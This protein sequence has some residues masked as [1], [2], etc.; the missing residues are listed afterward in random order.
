MAYC[1][2]ASTCA[3]TL[4]V[5][6]G[7]GER[8][9][10]VTLSTA[11]LGP[12]LFWLPCYSLTTDRRDNWWGCVHI[13][14]TVRLPH[15]SSHKDWRSTLR[16]ENVSLLYQAVYENLC[17][18]LVAIWQLSRWNPIYRGFAFEFLSECQGQA[19]VTVPQL[20]SSMKL[21]QESSWPITE[22][23]QYPLWYWNGDIWIRLEGQ[24]P[25]QRVSKHVFIFHSNYLDHLSENYVTA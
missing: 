23:K 17:H 11:G 14:D 6:R 3:C 7:L 19:A 15:T 5:R 25:N 13:A 9:V 12:D 24:M 22:T 21:I 1:H 18:R 4:S 20:L 16:S 2:L 10:P 8:S